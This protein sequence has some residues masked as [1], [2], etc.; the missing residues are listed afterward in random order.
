MF[1]QQWD[2]LC[3]LRRSKHTKTGTNMFQL[4]PQ[5]MQSRMILSL[6]YLACTERVQDLYSAKK[7]RMILSLGYL[8]C[9]ERSKVTELVLCQTFSSH[10]LCKNCLMQST[11]TTHLLNLSKLPPPQYHYPTQKLQRKTMMLPKNVAFQFIL[12]N[13]S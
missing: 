12:N 1:T 9:F 6:R 7:S 10:I 4:S 8:A 2:I 5:L 11:I 3:A 13:F